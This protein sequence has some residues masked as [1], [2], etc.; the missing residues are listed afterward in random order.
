MNKTVNINL[1][2]MFFHI[3]ENAYAK[4]QRYLSALKRSFEGVQGEEEI[5]AD[6][7]ARIAELFNQKIEEPRQVISIKELDEIIAVMG[8]PEDYAVDEEIFEDAPKQKSTSGSSST[9]T[10]KRLYRDKENAYIGGVSS[11]FG[12]YLAV[13]P[14]W[15]RIAWVLLVLLGFGSPILIYILLWILIP[16]AETTADKLSMK[17]KAVNIDNIQQKVKEG[18]ENVAD[19]VKNVDYERYSNEAKKGAKGFFST[20]GD[21]IMFFVKIFGKFIGAL[22]I[23]IGAITVLSLFISVVTAGSIDLFNP[24]FSELSEFVHND[25]SA[26][27]WLVLVLILFAVGIPFFFLFYLGLRILSRNLKP[28]PLA[29]KLGLLGLWL[30]SIIAFGVLTVDQLVAES[31]NGKTTTKT[32]LNIRAGDT[33]NLVMRTNENYDIPYGRSSRSYMEFDENGNRVRLKRNV[34]LIVRSTADSTGY[35]RVEKRAYARNESKART[36]A[37]A[38]GYELD[39]SN[40][41]LSLDGYFESSVKSKLRDQEVR[42]YVYIPEGT[43]L[44][45]DNNTYSYH[46]NDNSYRDLLINGTEERYLLL[47]NNKL[48]CSDCDEEI[49][50]RDRTY[51]N[52]NDWEYRNYEEG[53]PRPDWEKDDKDRVIINNEGIDIQVND[54]GEKIDVQIDR[55]SFKIKVD[56]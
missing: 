40:N 43:I 7:E 55:D 2:G 27:I 35:V 33:L 5:L 52:S 32:E 23:L 30:V 11:G 45:A 53:E 54:P 38:I 17:G 49:E 47:E 42:V 14:L 16:E 1:A 13:D 21:I 19:T 15:I 26:P 6:I 48:H 3:D 56:N 41:T 8:Q 50:D 12:H 10:N 9:G 36:L 46:R 18:F 28:M 31:H 34:R 44:Y 51:R 4:L 25:T 29:G 37:D 39:Y 20:I 22:F 24:G